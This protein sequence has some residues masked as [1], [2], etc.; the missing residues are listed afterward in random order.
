[1]DEINPFR[2]TAFLA[3]AM[4]PGLAALPFI[5]HPVRAETIWETL[6]GGD[7][8]RCAAEQG[9]AWLNSAQAIAIA[10]SFGYTVA[11]HEIDDGCIELEGIDTHGARVDITLD[12]TTGAVLPPAP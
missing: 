1:M 5:A 6:S 9:T 10:Q 2:L 12:G 8:M 11:E 7:D 3:L 4:I